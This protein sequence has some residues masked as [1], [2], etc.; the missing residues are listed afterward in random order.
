MARIQDDEPTPEMQAFSDMNTA[1]AVGALAET[2]IWYT[3]AGR[4]FAR[5]LAVLAA[6]ESQRQYRAYTKHMGGPDAQR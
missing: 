4:A 2:G 5:R 6:K 3:R 1:A